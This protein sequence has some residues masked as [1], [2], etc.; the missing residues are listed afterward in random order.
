[1]SNLEDASVIWDRL[2]A[3]QRETGRRKRRVREREVEETRSEEMQGS[4]KDETAS[5]WE[6]ALAFWPLEDRPEPMKCRRTVNNMPLQDIFNMKTHCEQLS[7]KEG[8]GS[9]SFGQ[10]RKLPDKMFK[11]QADNC[12]DK[13]HAVR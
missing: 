5:N 3:E 10:D 9:D 8:K 12:A 13:L 4:E 1:M 2:P 7:Q 6:L 11:E